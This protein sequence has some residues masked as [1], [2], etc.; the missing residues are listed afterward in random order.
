MPSAVNTG[1]NTKD[2]D[3]TVNETE[4]RLDEGLTE[5]K[6]KLWPN[7]DVVTALNLLRYS[8]DW[9]NRLLTG[10]IKLSFKDEG[11]AK[12]FEK[13]VE[14]IAGNLDQYDSMPQPVKGGDEKRGSVL[15]VKVEP[16]KG[17]DEKAAKQHF[18]EFFTVLMAFAKKSAPEIAKAVK[19]ND[20]ESTLSFQSEDERT[21]QDA[22]VLVSLLNSEGPDFIKSYLSAGRSAGQ[23]LKQINDPK[24]KLSQEEKDRLSE[25]TAALMDKVA[26]AQAKFVPG[27]M[28][29][30][31]K[32][33]MEKSMSRPEQKAALSAEYQGF[34]AGLY[35]LSFVAGRI[36]DSADVREIEDA[37]V[38]SPI[39]DNMFAVPDIT[40]DFDPSKWVCRNPDDRKKEVSDFFGKL[41]LTGD[42]TESQRW[43]L[44]VVNNALQPKQD[45]WRE[46]AEAALKDMMKKANDAEGQE[47][48]QLKA[49][50]AD[51]KKSLAE[52]D[53]TPTKLR[54]DFDKNLVGFKIAL[55]QK[56]RRDAI[57]AIIEK[58]KAD[59]A[60]AGTKFDQKGATAKAVETVSE[61]MP[62]ITSYKSLADL[63][64]ALGKV[65][66]IEAVQREK[67]A[68]D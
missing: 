54:A 61:M 67:A 40:M 37:H 12:E 39:F 11:A 55:Y 9:S 43:L 2:I 7:L 52:E 36:N 45:G 58:A 38:G 3:S 47:K 25:M 62:Q 50:I 32:A 35:A 14:M 23:N 13:A 10:R 59:A 17:A 41:Q 53:I 44:G 46:K 29:D 49:R 16:P 24:S 21:L 28:T 31:Q 22:F 1:M 30:A 68:Q 33:E 15:T 64:A 65:S 19:R 18:S 5:L 51:I 57:E 34:V 63:A 42:V 26:A 66:G 48:E 56:K 27:S 4:T 6:A 60:E 20:K 8:P